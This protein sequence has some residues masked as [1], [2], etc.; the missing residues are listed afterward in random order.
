MLNLGSEHAVHRPAK[1]ILPISA[2]RTD[3]QLRASITGAAAAR[4]SPY[5]NQPVKSTHRIKKV[6]DDILILDDDSVWKADVFT[7]SKLMYWS[8]LFEKVEVEQSA[9]RA[10]ITNLSRR[11]AVKASKIS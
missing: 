4:E 6:D 8:P 11:E 1:R 9:F 10:I 7:A 3:L 2:P 5:L